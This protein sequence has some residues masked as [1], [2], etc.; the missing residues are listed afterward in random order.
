MVKDHNVCDL[1]FL[2]Y[3]LSEPATVKAIV[4]KA[5]GAANQANVSPSQVESI[6]IPLPQLSVQRRIA[7]ILSA[8]DELIENNLRRIRI[9]E[10]M[11]RRLY[12]EWFVN[13]RFPGHENVRIVDSP[14]GPIPEDWEVATIDDVCERV[15]DGAHFSPKSVDHGLPMASAKD[16]QQWGLRLDTCRQI[17]SEDFEILVRNGCRPKKNDVLV[18]KDGS[19]LKHIF[20]M[21]DDLQVVLLSSVA[22]LRP[23]SK[24]DPHLLAAILAEDSN[25][26]R[27]KGYVTGAAL[28]RIILEDFK[29]FQIFVP[30]DSIQVG[31]SR[32]AKPV[33][34]LCWNLLDQNLNLRRAR[35]LILPRLLSGTNDLFGPYSLS[36]ANSDREHMVEK[37]SSDSPLAGTQFSSGTEIGRSGAGPDEQHPAQPELGPDQLLPI[38]ERD[39]TDILTVIRQVFSD[40]QPR[41]R[42]DAIRDVARALGYGRVG[43]RIQDVLHKDLLTAV[44]RGILENAGGELRLLFR[45]IRRLR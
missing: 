41:T 14:L 23:S 27:L 31:W 22:I 33:A 37:S 38:D 4:M 5:H 40:R 42:D 28:P 43:H 44:R 29:R 30:P 8:Y 6:E 9:L 3:A 18:A 24:I 19:Y 13:F 11:A 1:G 35:D 39:R 7:S 12:R 15:T 32:I 17:S 20:V 36:T 34:N 16:M 45:S 25:R 10:E 21:R 26:E 2:F